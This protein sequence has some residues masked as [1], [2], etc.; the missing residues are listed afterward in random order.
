M[1]KIL[2]LQE[3][4]RPVLPKVR[5]CKDYQDEERLLQRIDRILVFSGVEQRFLEK[6]L[7]LLRQRCHKMVAAGQKVLDGASAEI[8]HLEHARRALRCNVL[9]H[10]VGGG[11][12]ALSKMLAMSPL[13]RWFCRCEDFAEIQVPSKSTFADYAKWL[14]QEAMEQVHEQLRRA[15]AEEEQARI[16]GLENELDLSVVWLDSTCLKACIHFPADWVLLR[17]LVRTLSKSI[18][19]IRRHGLRHRI[20]EPEE[21]LRAINAQSMA[22]AEASRRK[23]GGKKERKRVLRVMKRICKTVLAHARRYRRV[24]DANWQESDLSRKEAEV[25]LRRMD[26]V[27]DQAPAAIKQ[28]HE[29]IIGERAV[30]NA[31]KILS[32]CESDLHV[33]VR[34]KAGAEVESSRREASEIDC[35]RQPAGRSAVGGSRQ[36]NSATVCLWPRTRRVLSCIMS[37]CASSH[38]ETRNGW[39]RS[40]ASSVRPVEAVSME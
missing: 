6:S 30:D 27:L 24:L 33:I 21:F 36:V 25:I 22:M 8:R 18:L 17:D 10:L 12:R 39:R 11:F 37:C 5:G 4:L 16:I 28:A 15:V 40:S 20:G 9:K 29:R 26:N 19:T 3:S 31:D 32:L 35:R 7:E 1:E 14:P 13:Y 38:P 34:R 2:P 23:P